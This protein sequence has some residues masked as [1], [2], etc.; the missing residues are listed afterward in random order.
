MSALSGSRFEVLD[1][2]LEGRD[3]ALDPV[4]LLVRV[5]D[6]HELVVGRH[7]GLL[8]PDDL[9]VLAA[10]AQVGALVVP[11]PAEDRVHLLREQGTGEVEADVPLLHIGPRARFAIASR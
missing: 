4:V 7:A 5:G 11:E 2:A 10:Q 1:A 3:E 6:E 8:D 9:R